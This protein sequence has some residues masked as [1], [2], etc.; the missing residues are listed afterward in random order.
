MSK[1]KIAVGVVA[2]VL[3]GCGGGGG[4]DP[5]VTTGSLAGYIYA[6]AGA[7]MRE[8]TQKTL[9]NVAAI[10]IAAG[11]KL[12][13][14]VNITLFITDLAQWPEANAIY[15]QFLAGVAVPPARAVA[16]KSTDASTTSS[17]PR[18]SPAGATPTIVMA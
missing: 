18:T 6:D 8:Q 11:G 17:I 1:W 16:P 9:E 14:L 5:V 2:V 15:Q 10:L 12:D 3:V 7:G 13:D 4:S